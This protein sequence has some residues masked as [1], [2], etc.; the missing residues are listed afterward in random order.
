MTK[1]FDGITAAF[2]QFVAVMMQFRLI[3]LV[4]ILV[5]AFLIYKFIQIVKQTRAKQLV[6]GIIF[7]ILAWL[8]SEWL[9][10]TT[11]SVL[12][13]SVV[14]SG[15][16]ALVIIFQPEIRNGL[17]MV[18][19]TKLANIGKRTS[20]EDD[21]AKCIENVCA[22]C[23]SLQR[24]KTGALI[25]F[26]RNTKLGDIIKSGTVVDSIANPELICN[27]FF[28]KAPLHDGA[29]IIR[30]GRIYAAGCILPL[31]KNIRLSK[32]LGT[33][34]RASLGMSENSD[35]AIVVV[36]EETGVISVAR[37]GIL[38]RGLSSSEL[39]EYL[40]K[41]MNINDEQP[42]GLLD[43]I[44]NRLKRGGKKNNE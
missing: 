7:V 12:L 32:D 19:R 15:L 5:V 6:T 31:T 8:V 40:K 14:S 29:M 30:D 9:Q 10:M 43:S 2:Y 18:S 25:V 21:I 3:D 16:I 24:T 27:I 42:E 38:K 28:N 13:K 41:Q 36:S 11:L 17:E 37:D 26:E 33:R 44:R 23:A 22:A 4:D 39:H 34:H 1:F 20:P 35:A